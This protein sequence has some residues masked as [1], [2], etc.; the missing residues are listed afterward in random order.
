[1]SVAENG[2]EFIWFSTQKALRQPLST[3]PLLQQNR[4]LAAHEPL[5]AFEGHLCLMPTR[6]FPLFIDQEFI[7]KRWSGAYSLFQED[8]FRL[9]SSFKGQMQIE[10]QKGLVY[11]NGKPIQKALLHNG[12]WILAGGH[13]FFWSSPLLLAPSL[14][15]DPLHQSVPLHMAGFRPQDK[16]P[17]ASWFE[18]IL[19]PPIFKIEPPPTFQEESATSFQASGLMAISSLTS[20]IASLFVTG[21][22]GLNLSSIFPALLSATTL[23]GFYSW[24]A[25]RRQTDK[26][27]AN[28]EAMNRYLAYLKEESNKMEAL[29]QERQTHFLAQKKSLI[30]FDLTLKQSQ[31]QSPWQ[32]PLSLFKTPCFSLEIP[33]LPWSLQNT[34]SGQALSQMESLD[35]SIWAW[36]CLHQGEVALLLS[37]K[38]AQLLWLYTLWC[39]MIFTPK[40][41]FV[42]IGFEK[43]NFVHPASL[44]EGEALYFSTFQDFSACKTRFSNFEWTICLHS[45]LM[46]SL[47]PSLLFSSTLF[48]SFSA[49]KAFWPKSATEQETWLL[50]LD[51]STFQ[52]AHQT[53]QSTPLFFP[54][55]KPNPIYLRQS[56]Y[57]SF[58][59]PEKNLLPNF[60]P[61]VINR[62]YLDQQRVANLKVEIGPGVFWD[63]KQ[64]GPHALVA[65]VTGSG[66]SEGLCSILFQLAFQNS[67]KLLRFVLID[68]KGGSFSV[69]LQDLPHTAACLTNLASQ[70][71]VRLEKALHQEIERRQQVLFAFLKQHPDGLPDL[72]H[73]VD[74][75]TGKMFSHILICVDE[76][77][78]L[79]AHFPDFMKFLQE[80][81]RIGRSLGLHL[82]LSTQKPAGLIDEQIWANTKTKLCFPVLEAADSKEVL[83]HD[84]AMQLTKSGEFILQVSQESEKKGRA[85][86]LKRAASGNSALFL[87]DR[88]G[89]WHEK[90]IPTIQDALHQAIL[91]RQEAVDPLLLSD[92]KDQVDTFSGIVVDHL[93]HLKPILLPFGLVLLIGPEQ[94][95]EKT[96]IQL[97]WSLRQDNKVIFNTSNFEI[98]YTTYTTVSSLW[99]LSG[100]CVVF[101]QSFPMPLIDFLLTKKDLTLVLFMNQ[102]AFRHEALL[103]K[104]T[105][106]LLAQ[107]SSKDQLALISEG[108]LRQEEGFPIVHALYAHTME[109]LIVGNR[110]PTLKE[111]QGLPKLP[112][113]CLKQVQIEATLSTLLQTKPALIGLETKSLKPIYLS[114][115]GL[116]LAWSS[117]S[118]KE[119][120]LNLALRLQIENPLLELKDTPTSGHLSLLDAS[121]SLDPAHDLKEAMDQRPVVFFG[122]G[123]NAW[124]YLLQLTLPMEI[125]GNAL[126]IEKGIGLDIQSACVHD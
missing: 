28:H 95:V 74:P 115:L 11:L 10:S 62:D 75:K 49:F 92:P 81:A 73:C 122:K 53:F 33:D 61:T 16:I 114:S 38:P 109:R 88:Q 45:S 117:P 3:L 57:E 30:E 36:R 14:Q 125:N 69:P 124:Q 41:R 77:G 113:F 79:K 65:G 83:G 60:D 67:A 8:H 56:A 20:A 94:N 34:P 78:Q 40:R 82:I 22:K 47:D 52:I 91:T 99:E 17:N 108:R 93:D 123:L 102:I 6:F 111:E 46:A 25:K 76:F 15:A 71:I 51:Q 66:K 44:L 50:C 21:Q 59:I 18:S 90:S 4:L 26:K 85:F 110:L 55:D 84:G 121:K 98:P 68:F 54:V 86:Y 106:K 96:L 27:L 5:F 97:A 29:R 32:L 23:M 70:E 48:N 9:F 39:W 101:G 31:R 104:A 107:V 87:Q 72:D 58:S 112:T 100:P 80:S 126:Y 63:L 43:P 118:A 119:Q 103:S 89:L 7:A 1:M 116:T 19:D 120:A 64:E 42:W 13:S 105:L 37:P 2:Y 12:D 24:Q 35:R